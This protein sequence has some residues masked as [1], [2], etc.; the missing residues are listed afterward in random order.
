MNLSNLG[1]SG[2][3]AAQNRLQTTGHNINNAATQGYNRQSVKVSTAGAQATG[4]GY[5]GLGVQ[6]DT[7][8]RAYNN[9]L[10]RQLVDSQ[11]KGAELGAYGTE[12]T[13][14]NNIMADR[15]VGIS[16]AL[17]KFF[18]GMQAVA[19]SPADPAARQELLGRASSLVG[20]LNDTNAFLD[21]QRGNINTQ[22]STVVRQIN[23]YVERIHD[24][25]NR[26]V[27]AKAAGSGHAPNDLLDTRDQAVAELN[28]LVGVN[29]IEQGDRF[30]LSFGRGQVLL[31][32]DTIYPL[33]AGP[34]VD[35]PSRT[36]V[37]YSMPAGNGK[38]TM[39]EI[40]DQYIRGGKLGGLLQ[41]RSQT[42]DAVQNDLGRLATGL[43]M[44]VNAQHV[45]GFDQVGR[46]GEAFFSLPDPSVSAS[47]RNQ[48]NGEFSAAF[49]N[50][51]DLTASDYKISY[52]GASY[53]IVRQPD[54]NLM[55]E[56]TTFPV[57]ID[58]IEMDFSG[59]ALAGDR[60]TMTPTRG[61]ASDIKLNIS[62]PA[63]IA[64][65][66]SDAGDADNG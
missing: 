59:T 37:S 28:E 7:V 58:G 46:P 10:Y 13:Q 17:Q 11:S 25:N 54:G 22:V 64:A 49:V 23:S 33:Q 16:P 62:N 39:T 30:G 56:G 31:S 27:T 35:D 8:E 65:A 32:S 63:D 55:Y 29:V 66:A 4:A 14:I 12:I 34:S 6:V 3:Q 43:A 53:A 9:F 41:Y 44:A 52:N 24:L 57:T 42:L 48:G 36:V 2:I 15:T 51:N 19:S 60:W 50:A 45:Q 47:E 61:S 5:V 40:G 26:I 18:D 20:Q 21:D 1:L 38:T